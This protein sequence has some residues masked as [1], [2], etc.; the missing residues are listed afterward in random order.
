MRE[1]LQSHSNGNANNGKEKNVHSTSLRVIILLLRFPSFSIFKAQ[2]ALMN[3]RIF[4]CDKYNKEKDL[5]A[6]VS[7][8]SILFHFLVCLRERAKELKKI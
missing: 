5:F 1:T 3:E 2:D 4:L 7:C 8:F 6:Y